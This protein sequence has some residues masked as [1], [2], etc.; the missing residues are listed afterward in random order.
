MSNS[1]PSTSAGLYPARVSRRIERLIL[2][3]SGQAVQ[4]WGLLRI[5]SD[6]LPQTL[7]HEPRTDRAALFA[8][9]FAIL[10]LACS[11]SAARA[12][13]FLRAR[14]HRTKKIRHFPR[15]AASP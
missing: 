2:V 10:R 14:L 6:P 1:A 13:D 11:A 3:G 12:I 5:T 15:S 7:P 4:L 8:L 9:A